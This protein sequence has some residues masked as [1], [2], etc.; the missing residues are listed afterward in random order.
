M[1]T[2]RALL[3]W[4]DLVFGLLV[5]AMLAFGWAMMTSLPA[6]VP[7]H[8]DIM[9]RPNGW[10][11]A[12]FA[13][14]F[15]PAMAAF[16]WLILMLVPL[17]DPLRANLVAGKLAYGEVRL[18]LGVFMYLIEVAVLGASAG[19]AATMNVVPLAIGLLFMVIGRNLPRVGRNGT[20]G[21]RLPSTLASD[22]VWNETHRTAGRYFTYA[23]AAAA[24]GSLAGAPWSFHVLLA[25]IIAMV[26]MS[27]I[28][29]HRAS[30]GTLA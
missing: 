19:M 20:M 11:S 3:T 30:R 27:F 9:G 15:A 18:A 13:A 4:H 21:I 23:G 26:V 14:Y 6:V 5:V 29:A 2:F 8:W 10:G 16:L 7:I 25:S 17:A 12:A 24:L 1:K 22:R 28:A